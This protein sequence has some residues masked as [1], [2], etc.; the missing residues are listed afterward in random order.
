MKPLRL[1]AVTVLA[2]CAAAFPAPASAADIGPQEVVKGRFPVAMPGGYKQGAKIPRGHTL[3]R[4]RV[5]VERDERGV[6][7]RMTCKKGQVIRT[8]AMNDPSDV[9]YSIDRNSIPY[10]NKRSLRMKL[11][12]RPGLDEYPARGRLY[13]LCRK[14]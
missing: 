11:F 12:P 1:L 5:A 14:R 9:G 2:A 3:I 6:P 8:L 4:R 10:G 7:M 13:V